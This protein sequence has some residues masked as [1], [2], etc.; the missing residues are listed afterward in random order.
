MTKFK[1]WI[2]VIAVALGYFVDLYDLLLFS[3]VRVASLKE[4]NVDPLLSGQLA[5]E[6]MNYTVLGMLIGGFVWGVIGD[7][8]GRLSVLFLSIATYTLANFINAAVQDIHT[9]KFCRFV[10]GFGIAG[11]LGIGITLISE[12]LP[13]NKRSI[14]AGI[15]TAAGML[16]AVTAGFLAHQLN[17]MEILGMSAWR[18]LFLL[19]GVFGLL[20]LFFRFSVGES[21]L[22]NRS[23]LDHTHTRG[24]LV[25]L[26]T[27]WQPFKKFLQSIASGLP[28]FIII[29]TFITLSPEY[30]K[31]SN[32]KVE[33]S[34]AVMW[35]YLSISLFDFLALMLSRILR[36]RKKVLLL[37]LSIQVI[38]ILVFT[39]VPSS[40]PEIF[41]L[42]CVFLGTGIGYWGI[43]VL[44][45]AENTGTNL[46]ATVTTAVP[47]VV[48]F[49]L[50][51]FSTLLFSPLKNSI[52]LEHAGVIV[53]LA[54]VG[55]AFWGVTAMK[56]RFE[57]EV[58][59]KEI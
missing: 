53:A 3:S 18:F 40:T 22:Y 58:D 6:L 21:E 17:G 19:G 35:C 7:K 29:G 54:A 45:A 47:N 31:L 24:D 27:H 2:P 48:R 4:L 26:F 30:G 12:S 23:V 1:F 20:L 52:G 38:S 51:P 16:G 56:D 44:T 14:A 5:T 57:Q 37:F 55:L 42:K 46:R 41:Y 15:I 13:R 25:Y 39:Y 43:M 28:V 9:Y 59:F 10:A 49:A 8:R 34:L 50:L 32:I 36:S 11:E 33:P